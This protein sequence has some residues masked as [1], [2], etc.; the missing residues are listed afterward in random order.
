MGYQH[1]LLTIAFSKCE[2]QCRPVETQKQ[3]ADN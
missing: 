3:V 2:Q 1:M